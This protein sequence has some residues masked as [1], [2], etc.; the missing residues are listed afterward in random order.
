MQM[1]EFGKFWSNLA[2]ITLF[3]YYF[4]L[5][6][7]DL[8]SRTAPQEQ[9]LRYLKLYLSRLL[10]WSIMFPRKTYHRVA[11]ASHTHTT[12]LFPEE[13][14]EQNFQAVGF[15][16]RS[17]Y[18]LWPFGLYIQKSETVQKPLAP[19]GLPS[20]ETWRM[21]ATNIP[22]REIRLERD[23][24]HKMPYIF[25]RAQR[26]DCAIFTVVMITQDF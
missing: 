13:I 18:L 16:M 20:D 15:P 22:Q 2:E 25:R 3:K 12:S 17:D 14:S 23:F 1:A 26:F 6:P 11:R 8:F 21:Q 24:S 4:Q 9:Y 5:S 19:L 10:M 7:A